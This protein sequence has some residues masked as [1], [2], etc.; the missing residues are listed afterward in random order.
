MTPVIGRMRAHLARRDWAA[1]A[2][3]ELDE[4][5]GDIEALEA[6]A[7]LGPAKLSESVLDLRRFLRKI[8]DGRNDGGLRRAASLL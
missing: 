1:A 8:R 4:A 2:G 5:L 7:A 6:R 3:A